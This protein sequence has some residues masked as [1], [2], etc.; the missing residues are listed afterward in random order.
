MNHGSIRVRTDKPDY[1]EIPD[2]TYMWMQSVYGDISELIADDIPT[3][4][5]NPVITTTYKD[6]NLFHDLLQGEQ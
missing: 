1:S 3:P 4:Y 5:R 2:H 6:A